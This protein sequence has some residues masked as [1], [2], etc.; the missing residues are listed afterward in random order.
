MASARRRMCAD[1]ICFFLHAWRI[2]SNFFSAL[3]TRRWIGV[4]VTTLELLDKQEVVSEDA[5][6]EDKVTSSVELR[7]RFSEILTNFERLFLTT[8]VE[9]IRL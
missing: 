1:A 2:I 8:C 9:F 6:P 7:F 3:V 4:L 5:E